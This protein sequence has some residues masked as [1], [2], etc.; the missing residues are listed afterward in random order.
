[1]QVTLRPQGHSATPTEPPVTSPDAPPGLVLDTNAVLDWLWFADPAM[2]GV[3]AAVVAGR[4]RW[5]VTQ[6]TRAELDHV[7]RHRLP[8]R[9]GADAAAVLDGVQR[10]GCAAPAPALPPALRLPCRDPDDQVFIDLAIATRAAWLLTRDRAL[11]ALAHRASAHGVSI[12]PPSRW[13]PIDT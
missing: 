1:M 12:V 11:L 10:W 13:R 8:P 9:P 2:H 4:C 6:A 3:A 5:W 7:L